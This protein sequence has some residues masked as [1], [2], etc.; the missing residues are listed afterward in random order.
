[1]PNSS[2]TLVNFVEL[3]TAIVERKSLV[4]AQN[5]EGVQCFILEAN[6]SGNSAH[7]SPVR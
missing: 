5:K 2:S 7:F 3:S 1:M 6:Q 4:A